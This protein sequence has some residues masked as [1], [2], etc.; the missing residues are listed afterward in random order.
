MSLFL[1][2]LLVSLSDT[3]TTLHRKEL[4]LRTAFVPGTGAL[5]CFG[6]AGAAAVSVLFFVI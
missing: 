6:D 5:F 3:L 4:L 2:D 1:L